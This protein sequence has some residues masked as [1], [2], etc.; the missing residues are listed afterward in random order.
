MKANET[1]IAEIAERGYITEK[2]INLLKCR[3]NREGRKVSIIT[4]LN[5][6]LWNL[7]KSKSQVVN[8]I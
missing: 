2:E 4:N 6:E 5:F 3:S 1:I 8:R 7:R